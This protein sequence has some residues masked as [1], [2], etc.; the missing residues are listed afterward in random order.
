D[1]LTWVFKLRTDAMIAPNSQGV[2]ERAL[3]SEDVLRSW[4][5]IADPAA[6][7]NG[8]IFFNRWVD[9]YDAPD[10]ETVRLVTKSP[11]AWADDEIGDALKG[12]IVPSEWREQDDGSKA[13]PVGARPC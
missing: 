1:D 7:S 4:D 8:F 5:R 2:P 11:Y 9:S 10:P 6:G 13:G 12:A 3:D